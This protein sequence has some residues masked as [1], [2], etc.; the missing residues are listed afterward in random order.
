MLGTVTQSVQ[1]GSWQPSRGAGVELRPVILPFWYFELAAGP[2]AEM[3]AGGDVGNVN[4]TAMGYLM[5]SAG[6]GEIE[7]RHDGHFDGD[8]DNTYE[9]R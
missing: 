4:D 6:G 3:K 5:R 2:A 7:D 1:A 8:D 9:F